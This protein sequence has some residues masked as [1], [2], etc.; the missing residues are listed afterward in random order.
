VG[1]G[2]VDIVEEKQKEGASA[3]EW[4]LLVLVCLTSALVAYS[5]TLASVAGSVDDVEQKEE[6]GGEGG[7]YTAGVRHWRALV[8]FTHSRGEPIGTYKR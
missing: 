7:F 8:P 6:E 1:W 4:G 2:S 5:A 3:E